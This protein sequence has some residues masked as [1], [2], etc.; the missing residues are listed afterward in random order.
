MRPIPDQYVALWVVVGERRIKQLLKVKADP[1]V[2]AVG[3]VP[4]RVVFFDV[5]NQFGVTS[6]NLRICGLNSPVMSRAL[7]DLK[8]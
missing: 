4:D 2:A 5:C 6:R 1:A 8:T 3:M 7:V